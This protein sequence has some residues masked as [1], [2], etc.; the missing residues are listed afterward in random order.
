VTKELLAAKTTEVQE[1]EYQWAVAKA[2]VAQCES[3]KMT[4]NADKDILQVVAAV[5]KAKVCKH[6]RCGLTSAAATTIVFAIITA[7][8]F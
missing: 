7:L 3:E 5:L 2:R 4:I 1:C 6:G 8:L